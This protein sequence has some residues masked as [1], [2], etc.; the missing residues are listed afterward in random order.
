MEMGSGWKKNMSK[1]V[2]QQLSRINPK[3]SRGRRGGIQTLHRRGRGGGGIQTL[4][5]RDCITE[6]YSLSGHKS[7]CGCE[8]VSQHGWSEGGVH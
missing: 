4:H 1:P 6:S 7:R 2:K 8:C 3:V 5:I